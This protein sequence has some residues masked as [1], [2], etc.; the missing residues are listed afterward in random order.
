MKSLCLALLCLFLNPIVFAQQIDFPATVVEDDA[1]LTKVMPDLAGQALSLYKE[2]DRDKYLGTLFRLQMVAGR[3]ADADATLASLR[4]LRLAA[5]PQAVDRLFPF[6]IYAKAKTR[7]TADRMSFDEAFKQVFRDV[8]GRLDDTTAIQ[9]QFWFGADLDR[10]RDD[11]RTAL[12]RQQ[13]KHTIELADALDLIRKYHFLQSFRSFMPLTAELFAEDDR[14]RYLIQNDILIKTRDGASIA[15]MVVRPRAGASVPQPTLLGFTIYA[16]DDDEFVQTKLAAARGYVGVVAYT[17]GKGRSPDAAVPYEHD[18]DDAAA[19]IEWISQQVWSDG[20]VGMYGSSYNGYAQWAAAKRLPPALKAIMPSATVAPGIDVPMEGNVFQSFV[21]QWPFY[22]T[23]NK[24]LD[25]ATYN[26]RA[27]WNALNRTWYSTGQPYRALDRIDGTPNP[28]FRR[29][30]EHPSYDAYWQRMIPFRE[31]FAR[32]DI[33]VLA[34]TGY[35]D[36]GQVGVLYYLTEHNRYHPDANHTLLVGPYEHYLMQTGPARVVEGYELDP[37]ALI[38]VQELRYQWFDHVLKS[39]PKPA[40]LKNKVNY[41][42][43]G[44]NEWKHAPSLDAMANGSLRFH[45]TSSRSEGVYRLSEAKPSSDAF[46]T[47]KIDFTDRSDVDRAVSASIVSKT[48][49]SHNGIAF[50]SDIFKQP[51]EFSGLFSGQLDFVS[52][53]KDFDVYVALYEL[54]PSGEYFQLSSY[55][56]RT[57]YARD[58][59]QRQLLVP[60]KRQQL[61]FKSGRITSRKFQAGSRLVAVLSINKQPDLQINYGTGKDVSDESIEDAKVPLQVKWYGDSYLD[62]PVWR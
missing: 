16:N 44:S 33:P 21:Y 52:N 5:N 12:E 39:G 13:G 42:V 38:D 22:T 2:S 7:Q 14:K 31:E 58:R 60:G 27:R 46:T 6:V 54:M 51:T 10:A 8:Y 4:E 9:M 11:L 29:W 56:A 43:M 36:G 61:A 62:I 41:Q 28:V 17:R 48:L 55:M 53:K 40:L 20:Q 49:D 30:L 35:F 50:V 34:T 1:A 24:A 15:A 32:I 57:S 47:L 59:S 23:N 26:D 3:Y 45:L 25:D 37:V 18:G 19:V